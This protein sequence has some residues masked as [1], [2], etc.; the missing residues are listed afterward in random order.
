MDFKTRKMHPI[1]GTRISRSPTAGQLSRQAEFARWFEGSRVVN[2]KGLPLEVYHGG[3]RFDD[4]RENP[5]SLAHFASDDYAV[6][7]GYADQ[8][9]RAQAELKALFLS[10]KNPLD[11]RD[12]QTYE[13][14][15]GVQIEDLGAASEWGER[16]AMAQNAIGVRSGGELLE[17]A[18]KAGYDG[19]IFFDTD[20]RNR[21]YHTSYAFFDPAQARPAPGTDA[22]LNHY[23]VKPVPE[24]SNTRSE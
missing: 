6:A 24:E 7:D 12:P 9:P 10:M 2:A 23:E 17:K 4:F 11:L 20:I 8:Y 15:V 16:T 21:G 13:K 1:G 3:L 22:R 5:E 14:W 19:V 18:R